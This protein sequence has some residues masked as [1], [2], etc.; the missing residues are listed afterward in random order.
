MS[1]NSFHQMHRVTRL[2]GDLKYCEVG[3]GS[4]GKTDW[5][6]KHKLHVNKITN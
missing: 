6:C 5:L 4:E 3:E 1:Y 2:I